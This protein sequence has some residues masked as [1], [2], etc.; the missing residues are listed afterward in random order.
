MVLNGN[1]NEYIVL[2]GN[3]RFDPDS[4]YK[5]C[6]HR[7]IS[8]KDARRYANGFTNAYI[9]KLHWAKNSDVPDIISI[10]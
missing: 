2:F 9:F 3:N 6:K 4:H 5:A 8:I 10:K 7:F 1:N